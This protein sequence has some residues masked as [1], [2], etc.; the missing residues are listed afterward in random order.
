MQMRSGLVGYHGES[1][2]STRE[3]R[4]PM[5]GM[6]RSVLVNGVLPYFIFQLLTGRGWAPVPALSVAALVPAVVI[7]LAWI[8]TR[9]LET[10]GVISLVS[11]GLGTATTLVS[12]NVHFVLVKDSLVTGIF[13]LVCLGSLVMPR[14]LMFYFGR[15]FATNGNPERIAWWNGLW[16]RPVFRR[17]QR[18]L[19]AVWGVAY[20]AEALL[21][22]LI[23]VAFP[24]AVVLAVSPFLA[25][26]VTAALIL[27]TVGYMRW[28]V[29]HVAHVAD[30]A[31]V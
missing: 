10:I 27:G 20:V 31:S 9:R 1:S 15:R 22:Y 6:W 17:D 21:R 5:N 4:T 2:E 18:I 28:R 24:P 7:L 29:A 25:L 13:G 26:G 30:K 8:R 19:T 23:A 11:I 16:E 3:K 12:G 14:P